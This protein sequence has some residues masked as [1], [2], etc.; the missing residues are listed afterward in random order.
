MRSRTP[1]VVKNNFPA[2]S[3]SEDEE[4]VHKTKTINNEKKKEKKKGTRKKG[5]RKKIK[6]KKSSSSSG[7]SKGSQKKSS[8]NTVSPKSRQNIKKNDEKYRL[9]QD[10]GWDV[11]EWDLEYLKRAA[12]GDSKVYANLGR[13]SNDGSPLCFGGPTNQNVRTMTSWSQ[14]VDSVAGKCAASTSKKQVL[15]NSST[16]IPLNAKGD[17]GGG[18]ELPCDDAH[19]MYFSIQPN[20]DQNDESPFEFPL[21]TPTF[22]R[23]AP[24]PFY[25]PLKRMWSANLWFGKVPK[26]PSSPNDADEDKSEASCVPI[27]THLHNDPEDNLYVLVKGRKTFRIYSPDSVINLETVTPP[28]SIEKDGYV[29]WGQTQK[30]YKGYRFSRV[31]GHEFYNPQEF[32]DWGKDVYSQEVHL[33]DGDVFYLPRGWYHEVYTTCST[34]D[35]WHLAVNHWFKN[36]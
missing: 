21:D 24:L 4:S 3:N 33:E 13:R 20:V 7:S 12:P 32:P 26:S 14:Y 1:F 27:H 28:A 8:L 6:K 22:R 2:N 11:E 36:W 17:R 19:A 30:P 31:V 18:L 23:D 34:E 16:Y 29:E 35:R 9:L 15:G 5:T 10:L 25:I